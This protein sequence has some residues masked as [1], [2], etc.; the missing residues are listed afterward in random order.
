MTSAAATSA[1]ML[2][3]FVAALL[4]GTPPDPA[5]G[6]RVPTQRISPFVGWAELRE[7]QLPRLANKVMLIN[8]ILWR[9][10]QLCPPVIRIQALTVVCGDD[11][12]Y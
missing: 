9:F 5:Y 7:A 12:Y 3:G 11:G 8:V 10:I 4:S 6:L 2:L 1:A